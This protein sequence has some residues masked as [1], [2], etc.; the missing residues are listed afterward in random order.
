[1]RCILT[2]LLAFF[3]VGNSFGQIIS[4]KLSKETIE[5][6]ETFELRLSFHHSAPLDSLKYEAK[7][8][9]FSV[10][11]IGNKLEEN[12]N[13][14]TYNL[15]Q[16]TPFKDTFYKKDDTYHWEGIYHLIAWDSAL[17]LIPEDT[18][19]YNNSKFIFNSCALVVNNPKK[20][21]DTP[22]YDI[23]ELE[24]QLPE[25]NFLFYSIL[26]FC[27]IIALG[28]FLFVHFKKKRK[29][30]VPKQLNISLKTY[31]LN[32]IIALEKS[33]LYLTDLKE[34]YFRLSIITRDFLTFQYEEKYLDKT[35]AEIKLLL[36]KNEIDADLIETI[37]IILS[38]S[39]LV[40]FA[41]SKPTEEAIL[42]ATSK[43]KDVVK[44][45]AN[46]EITVS[47]L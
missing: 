25:N 22:I 39:D 34:Y 1:M 44:T 15:E 13:Y 11:S 7:E 43:A 3:F 19:T 23:V 17:V 30:T 8:A 14:Q 38:Q 2:Y 41:K 29:T 37:S 9:N 31:T 45:I 12:N 26:I 6:G 27:V 10:K 36:K 24:T 42:A 40:K 20:E 28:I 47:K 4:A 21:L 35:T 33:K 5:I 32:K 18:L 46:K 16:F